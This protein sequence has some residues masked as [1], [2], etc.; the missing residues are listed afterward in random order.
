M[1]IAPQSPV[2]EIG[3]NFMATCM[4]FN[5]SEV[6]ADDLDWKL[7]ETII[8]KEQYTKINSSALNVTIRITTENSEW[9]FCLC[10]EKPGY[11]SLN[12]GKFIHGISLKKGCK[13]LLM[14]WMVLNIKYI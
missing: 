14:L 12:K 6:T 1:V 2:L 9:L 5:T 13:Y 4:I 8:P 10:K 3:T 7:S 11:V